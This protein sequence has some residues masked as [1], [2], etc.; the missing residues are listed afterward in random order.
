MLGIVSGALR[1]ATREESWGGRDRMQDGATISLDLVRDS[2]HCVQ[3][4]QAKGRKRF[5]WR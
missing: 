4:A 2:D 3:S 5:W 1:V